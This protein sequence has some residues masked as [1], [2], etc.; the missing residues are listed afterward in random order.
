MDLLTCEVCH[1]FKT[2]A[3]SK[4]K[5]LAC[6]YLPIFHLCI[7]CKDKDK[8]ALFNVAYNEQ[9]TLAHKLFCDITIISLTG[10]LPALLYLPSTTPFMRASARELLVPFFTPLVWCC[11]GIRNQDLPLR[12]RT[13]YQLSYRGGKKGL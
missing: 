8:E 9:T 3:P 7:Y 13:L 4:L 5:V 12:K 6:L 2:D 1:K 10:Y 11:P